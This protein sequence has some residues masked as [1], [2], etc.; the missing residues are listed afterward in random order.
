MAT[1]L[2][3][4]DILGVRHN[5]AFLLALLERDEVKD[6]HSYT[7]FIEDHL[8]ALAAEPDL[9]VAER[10]PRFGARGTGESIYVH[11]PDGLT[12]EFRTYE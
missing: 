8:D 3:G 12:V 5:V 10:G 2:A 6:G 1:A 7:R 4:Y 9:T 11:D